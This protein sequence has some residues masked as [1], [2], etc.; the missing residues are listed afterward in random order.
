MNFTFVF[1]SL[2]FVLTPG[3]A[4]MYILNNSIIYGKKEGILSMFGIFMEE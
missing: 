2:I 1:T 3:L 4:T